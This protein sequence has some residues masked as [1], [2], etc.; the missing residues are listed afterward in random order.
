[1]LQATG[2]SKTYATRVL[3]DAGLEVRAG[4]VHA[5]L[6]AN[7][8]GKSTLAKI[9]AGV[10][11]ADE[12]RFTLDGEPYEPTSRRHARDH[13]VEIVLQELSLFE[14]LDVAENLFFDDLPRTRW[15]TVARA[16]LE[17][18]ARRALERVGLGLAPST[19]VMR[20]G[21]AE[22]QLVEIAAALAR[23]CRV[24]ILD[25]P[26][27]TLPDDAVA[28]LLDRLRGLRERG[29]AVLLI[30]HR[31]EEVRQ[32][33]DR[34]TVLR[35]GVVTA[36]GAAVEDGLEALGEALGLHASGSSATVDSTV[37]ETRSLTS[38]GVALEVEELCWAPGFS[39]SFQVREGT[40][41]GI[42]G[43]VGAG[44]TEM[45]ESLLGVRT[46]TGTVRVGGV[47]LGPG[48]PSAAVRAGL[49]LVPEERQSQGLFLDLSV[50]ENVLVGCWD[51][52]TTRG[53]LDLGGVREG[54]RDVVD[55]VGVQRHSLDQPV[56]ELSGGNQQRVVLARWFLQE[57]RVLL[58]DEPSRGVDVGAR[59]AVWAALRSQVQPPRAAVVASSDFDEL[60]A[61][62]DE[63]AVLADGRLGPARPAGS[64]SRESLLA[65]AMGRDARLMEATP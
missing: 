23:E 57:S 10:V 63:I 54:A 6:G 26:T 45:L 8:A 58:L 42:G 46:R 47:E 24:L 32:V 48:R 29:V 65:A 51:R 43:L 19:P 60:L 1:M 22:R 16:E 25:E 17:E 27:A 4:E 62:C 44:R 37:A 38:C 50:E 21:A 61:L 55:R 31:L 12:G 56:R 39:A 34:V 13:G 11:S 15:G 14:T 52:F 30:T 18:R 36:A 59:Q 3:D 33:A 2:V 35:D 28:L 9:V 53:L 7:G 49:G 40:I 41:L 64:W 5:L 20:L